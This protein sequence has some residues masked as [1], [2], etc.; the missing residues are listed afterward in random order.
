MTTH[1]KSKRLS[2]DI[3][4]IAVVFIALVVFYIAGRIHNEHEK[5]ASNL[6]KT[7][8]NKQRYSINNPTSIW[9]VVNKQRPLSTIGFV[10]S[11]LITPSVSINR[12]SNILP[13]SLQPIAAQAIDS[14]FMSAKTN[15]IYLALTSAYV[16][17]TFQQ[18][19]YDGYLATQGQAAADANTIRP[20][21]DESQVGLSA[22]L[23]AANKKCVNQI[24][25]STT[26]EG[27]WLIANAY[28]FGFTLR[29]PSGKQN[30]TGFNYEPWHYRYVGIDLATQLNTNN[31]TLEQFFNLSPAPNYKE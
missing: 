31:Q 6:A 3:S 17:Y 5:N 15:N 20:G 12:I 9:V 19:V 21:Y 23:A 25:F 7:S 22:D 28:K 18:G 14:M 30:I 4:V 11:T 2:I 8:I 27:K 13:T 26:P 16:P 24:C 10:P 1:K 29:Y